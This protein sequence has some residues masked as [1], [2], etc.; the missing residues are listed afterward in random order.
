MS[1][2][3]AIALNH[4]QAEFDAILNLDRGSLETIQLDRLKASLHHAYKNVPYYTQAF[5]EAGICIDDINCL[6][7]I[8]K[9]PFTQKSDLR[10]NYPFSLFAIPMEDV[11]RVHA[12]SGTSGKPTVVGYSQN[13]IKTWASVMTRSMLVAGA[14]TSDRY[15]DHPRGER[16]SKPN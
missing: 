15:V 10:D 4:E 12:S 7:D 1:F 14:K 3:S 2:I 16:F 11:V 6:K 8:E 13:D 5:E 9:L